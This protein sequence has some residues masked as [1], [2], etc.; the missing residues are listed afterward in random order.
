MSHFLISSP[1]SLFILLPLLFHLCLFHHLLQLFESEVLLELE[2]PLLILK[3]LLL[4]LYYLQLLLCQILL[5]FKQFL[6][7]LFLLPHYV[8]LLVID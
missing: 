5:L 4:L 2:L 8:L 1:L 7:L 6:Q 3:L